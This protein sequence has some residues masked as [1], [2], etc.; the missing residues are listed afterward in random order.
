MRNLQ[1]R[2]E[3]P[4]DGDSSTSGRPAVSLPRAEAAV[5]ELLAALGED[6]DR[7]GLRETPRRVARMYRDL[8]S[9]M[10]GDPAPHLQRTFAEAHSE[11]VLVRDIDFA[12][13]CE[14][15]LLPF[16]GRAHVA[17]LP[18][19]RVVGLSKLARTVEVFARRPQVQERLTAQVADAVMTHLDAL[20]ALV[21][22]EAEHLC[23]KVRGVE[24]PNAVT[25][26]S[27]VRGVFKSSSTSRAEAMALLGR[28]M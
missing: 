14:H 26:T 24:K 7:E 13:L 22:I 27:A 20:G 16:L 11:I 28:R 19:D 17:Y 15:H 3:A 2:E 21:V 8:F 6:P 18:K 23:M 5:R 25:V 9:G 12:S 4:A 10:G 1:L